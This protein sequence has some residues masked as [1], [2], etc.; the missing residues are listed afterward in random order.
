[1]KKLKLFVLALILLSGCT[2]NEVKEFPIENGTVVNEEIKNGEVT[3]PSEIIK[4]LEKESGVK[5]DSQ[6]QAKVLEKNEEGSSENVEKTDGTLEYTEEREDTQK[7]N[8]QEQTQKV[9]ES[10]K[11]S[12]SSKEIS[13][14][15][16][17]G[18]KAVEKF[19]NLEML[20]HSNIG[21]E[22]REVKSGGDS[23]SIQ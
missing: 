10:K 6:S 3:T 13:K 19:T 8:P 16:S 21:I 18:E 22:V 14:L 9:E 15:K 11:E 4:N 2:N 7:K 12:I 17:K 20:E 23:S 5:Q 1:M